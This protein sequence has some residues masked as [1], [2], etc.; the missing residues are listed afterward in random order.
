MT[1]LRCCSMFAALVAVPIALGARNGAADA[2]PGRYM[3]ATDTVLD[4]KTN[5]I[6]QRVAQTASY[7]WANALS[8]CSGLTLDGKVWRAPSMKEIQTLVD[9]TRKN[10]AIDPA[11]FPNTNYVV[12]W[13]SS[14]LNGDA[15]RA[16][17][18]DFATGSVGNYITTAIKNV[19]CVRF[20]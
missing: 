14:P 12:F 20:P 1:F 18:I 6:W 15:T 10:P 13:T 5:L 16:W 17:G 2:P 4:T 19:R 3:I 7:T 11:A 9:D 8:Y